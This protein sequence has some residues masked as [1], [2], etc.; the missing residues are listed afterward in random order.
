[1]IEVRAFSAGRSKTPPTPLPPFLFFGLCIGFDEWF[2]YVCHAFAKDVFVKFTT[3]LGVEGRL[4]KPR[5][6][7]WL[8]SEPEFFRYGD[9][10][11]GV[12]NHWYKL[13]SM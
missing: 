2:L 1:M 13:L 11:V 5:H 6:W 7:G 4:G 10:T 8:T 12:P 3:P 9:W